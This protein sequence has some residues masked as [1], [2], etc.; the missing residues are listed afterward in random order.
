MTVEQ[1]PENIQRIISVEEARKR[2]SEIVIP[3]VYGEINYADYQY[4]RLLQKILLYGNERGDRT[5]TGTLSI[6]GLQ[7]RFNLE[8]GF[9]LLTTKKLFTKG[10]THELLWFLKGDTN[11]KYLNEHGVKFWDE[12]AD[13]NGELGPVYGKQWRNWETPENESIDQIAELIEGIKKNPYSRR[14]ILSA[15]NVAD[16]KKMALPPCHLLTQF[17]V[18]DGKLSAQLYQRSADMF[19]GVPF[20][21]A[22]YSM[23]VHTMAQQ[24][25]LGVGEFV[26]TFGDAHIYKN[27]FEQALEQMERQPYRAPRLALKTCSSIDAYERSDFQILNYKSHPHI[28]ADISV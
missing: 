13:E 5:G 2:A 18:A 8:E 23:L 9:P 6:F 16:I 14:H 1:S 11:I 22:S 27:H 3:P 26:H 25:G 15:W 19:L 12:W 10:I 28:P 4:Q 20:N 21:I 17:Y 7:M 24:T